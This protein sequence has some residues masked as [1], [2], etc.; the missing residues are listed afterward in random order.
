V[1][2][3]PDIARERS[4]WVALAAITLLALA[5]RVWGLTFGLPLVRARPDELLIIGA[6]LA[7][8]GGNPNPGF[9]D[10]PALHFYLLA[11]LY[12]IYYAWGLLSGVFT[13]VA[14]FAQQFRVHWEPLFYIGRVTTALMGT[15]TVVVMFAIV[16]PLFGRLTALIASFFLALAFL[17]VRD[18]H[19]GTT[20]VPLTFFLMAALLAMVRVHGNPQRDEARLAGILSGCAVA[21]KYTAAPIA[22]PIA[23]VAALH[24][25]RLTGGWRRIVRESPLLWMAVP[26]VLMFLVLNPYLILDFERAAEHLRILR[27][28]SAAGMTPPEL[29]GRGWTYHLPFSLGYGLGWPLLV[30]GLGGLIWSGFHYPA[31]TLLLASFPVAYYLAVGA[32]YNVF[33]RYMVP[34]VPFVCVFAA[35]LVADLAAVAGRRSRRLGIAMAAVLAGAIVMPSAASVVRF[36]VLI[37]REDSRVVAGRWLHEHVPALSTLYST[38]NPYGHVQLE[39][40]S[41][42]RYRYFDFDRQAGVFTE[43]RRKTTALPD[44]II[45]QRSALPYSHIAPQVVSLLASD[46]VLVHV[47]QAA[48]LDERRTMYDIQ[49]AFYAPYGG[50]KGVSRP[51]PNL[52]I[53]QRRRTVPV[54]SR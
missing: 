6:S 12:S 24:A 21:T 43:D 34:V 19:Y 33:V 44:W 26:A 27:V 7:I 22:A 13:S 48:D 32:G 36:N 10:Y 4:T 23:V 45:V 8:V 2:S 29:L 38:G 53:Y 30:T 9:F 11:G 25:S 3:G 18:S 51:G 16:R 52:E 15:A 14:Q 41:P 5:V 31:A 17:H 50:F 40:G 42:P 1:V 28:S 46:Y 54:T 20:D 39:R 35:V 47:V 37:S 49:D